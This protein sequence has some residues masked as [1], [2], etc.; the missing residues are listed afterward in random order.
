VKVASL[1][2]IICE[3]MVIPDHLKPEQVKD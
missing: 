1:K 2:E 3:L